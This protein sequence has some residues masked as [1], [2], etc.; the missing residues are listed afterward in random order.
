MVEAGAIPESSARAVAEAADVT[1]TMV[2]NT[3]DVEE[4]VLPG[5]VKAILE[6]PIYARTSGYVKSW[7]TD[8]GTPVKAGQLLA[9]IDA[10]EVDQQLQAAQADLQTAKANEDLSSTTATLGAT[11][12]AGQQL[13]R[14]GATGNATGPHLHFEITVRGAATNPAPAL[15][16]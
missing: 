1:M 8:I 9:V 13:G 12:S 14:V 3:P 16:L 7:K 2:S 5:S 4:V 11:F 15:G 6:T 10:P